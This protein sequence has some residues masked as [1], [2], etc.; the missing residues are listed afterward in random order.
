MEGIKMDRK[1]AEKIVRDLNNC[2]ML[3]YYGATPRSV[4][5]MNVRVSVLQ[6]DIQFDDWGFYI[7]DKLNEGTEIR[8]RYVNLIDNIEMVRWSTKILT[9]TYE[10]MEIKIE[11]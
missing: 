9:Y 3:V 1:D 4:D 5:P 6:A 11:F 7:R 8:V 2:S 10:T